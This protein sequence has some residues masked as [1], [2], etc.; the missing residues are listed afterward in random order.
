MYSLDKLRVGRMTFRLRAL[1]SG[2]MPRFLGPVIRGAFGHALLRAGC[3]RRCEDKKRCELASPCAYVYLFETPVSEETKRL[4][5]NQFLPHPFVLIPPPFHDGDWKRG[6][7]LYFSMTLF[8]RGLDYMPHIVAAVEWMAERG[9]GRKGR[10]I[11]FQLLEVRE[12]LGPALGTLL[13]HHEDR[14]FVSLRG[15]EADSLFE[16]PSSVSRE[17]HVRF[18]TPL[19][20]EEKKKLLRELSFRAFVRS[21]LSRLSSVLAFHCGVELDVDFRGLLERASTVG[22]RSSELRIFDQKRSSGRQRREVWLGGL[23]GDIVWEGDA[24]AELWPLLQ[25]GQLLHAGKSTAQGLGSYRLVDSTTDE[26]RGVIPEHVSDGS[27]RM[28]L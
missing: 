28:S 14:Q 21:L 3:P 27:I 15:C 12:S 23:R 17:C 16:A 10:W 18:E 19:R 2:A 22:V 6:D 7:D 5:K 9:L 8:G 11:P 13:W 1:G 20:I 4:R 25:V 26:R 24:I